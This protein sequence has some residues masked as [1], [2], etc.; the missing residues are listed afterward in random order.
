M[1]MSVFIR[2][3]IKMLTAKSQKSTPVAH[4]GLWQQQ[5]TLALQPVATVD[6]KATAVNF[7]S[8]KRGL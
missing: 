4:R 6:F 3:F 8:C 5:S 2:Q 7:R 1:E